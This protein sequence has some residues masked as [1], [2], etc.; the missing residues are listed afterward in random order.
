M[1][2]GT[3]VDTDIV[4]NIALA[5]PLLI[6]IPPQLVRNFCNFRGIRILQIESLSVQ[7]LMRKDDRELE[8]L[9]RRNF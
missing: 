5:K 7:Q 6:A 8:N 1:D 3:A 9:K 4:S 2:V